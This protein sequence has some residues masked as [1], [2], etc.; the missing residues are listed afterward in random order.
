M[1][2]QGAGAGLLPVDDQSDLFVEPRRLG[3]IDLPALTRAH[4][5]IF[6]CKPLIYNARILAQLEK[7]A[8]DINAT[9]VLSR[10]FVA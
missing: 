4:G 7:F 1:A 8:R 10:K 5:W 9:S 3:S 6:R 2:S